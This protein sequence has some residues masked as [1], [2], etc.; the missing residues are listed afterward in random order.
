MFGVRQDGPDV[1]RTTQRIGCARDREELVSAC[2][3]IT[4]IADILRT[5]VGGIE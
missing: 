5:L 1:I 2:N 3:L 4:A